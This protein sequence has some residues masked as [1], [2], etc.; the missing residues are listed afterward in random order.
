[1]AFFSHNNLKFTSMSPVIYHHPLVIVLYAYYTHLCDLLT[2][3][4]LLHI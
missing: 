2:K 1:M 4:H 3:A